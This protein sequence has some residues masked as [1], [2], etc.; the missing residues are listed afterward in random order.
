M[1]PRVVFL[2]EIDKVA[3]IIVLYYILSL[4]NPISFRLAKLLNISKQFPKEIVVSSSVSYVGR[5]SLFRPVSSSS[6]LP[7]S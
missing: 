5:F 4:E 1:R 3:A 2:K 7:M 6:C